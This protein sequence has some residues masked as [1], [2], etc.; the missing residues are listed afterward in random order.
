MCTAA[1]TVP[2]VFVYEGSRHERVVREAL[3]LTPTGV[4]R[5]VYNL[6]ELR[7]LGVANPPEFFLR[8]IEGG[9]EL[10][11][12]D[13]IPRKMTPESVPVRVSALQRIKDLNDGESVEM[14]LT[15][16]EGGH[17]MTV[18]YECQPL[19]RDGDGTVRLFT[20]DFIAVQSG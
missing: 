11:P 1:P 3:E 9:Y 10:L 7:L 16:T 12:T 4:S 15:Y 19:L 5:V 6:R 20:G 14:T 2:G 18:A 17:R 8:K 13:E